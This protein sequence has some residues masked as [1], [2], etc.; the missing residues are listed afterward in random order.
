MMKS[1]TLALVLAA[2]LTAAC[3]STPHRAETP[4]YYQVLTQEPQWCD[5]VP[6]DRVYVYAPQGDVWRPQAWYVIQASDRTSGAPAGAPAPILMRVVN[7]TTGID[8]RC[9]LEVVAHESGLVSGDQGIVTLRGPWMC[10]PHE[11]TCDQPYLQQVRPQDLRPKEVMPSGGR[12]VQEV[13]TSR[14]DV[15]ADLTSAELQRG[16]NVRRCPPICPTPNPTPT[17]VPVPT[18]TPTPTPVPATAIAYQLTITGID[19][20]PDCTIWTPGG[21]RP[22]TSNLTS[23]PMQKDF[24]LHCH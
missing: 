12:S 5:Y 2:S 7:F 1:T 6:G 4:T 3:T 9:G 20:Q 8:R 11:I 18:P 14:S 22:I 17:P 16:A 15:Q 19:H 10:E 21:S 13:P 24:V 23:T